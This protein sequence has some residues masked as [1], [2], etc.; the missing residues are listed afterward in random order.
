MNA[1]ADGKVT[2]GPMDGDLLQI[3]LHDLNSPL[4]AIRMLV[5]LLDG[6]DDPDAARDVSDMREALDLASATIEGLAA[7]RRID[8]SSGDPT[9]FP[10]DLGPILRETAARPALRRG[11]DVRDVGALPASGDRA[12]LVQA[13]TDVLFTARRMAEPGRAVEVSALRL[14]DNVVIQVDVPGPAMPES[15]R[16]HLFEADGAIVLRRLK[17]PT[18]VFGLAVARRVV[19]RHRG[20]L[21]VMDGPGG[22]VAV[23]IQLPAARHPT[24]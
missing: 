4:T 17:L 18:T 12:A 14:V 24:G 13:I 20:T 15:V 5:E 23:R 3:F 7:L 9:W 21:D 6:G 2:S 11:V 19:E 10:L 1:S 8:A 22:G 16:L